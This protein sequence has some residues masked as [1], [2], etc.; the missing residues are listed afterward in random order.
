MQEIE[1]FK[2]EAL[3]RNLCGE[4]HRLWD[5]ME[6]REDFLQFSLNPKSI[7]YVALSTWEGWGL[8]TEY[9]KKEFSKHINRANKFTNKAFLYC[10][11]EGQHIIDCTENNI[12][13][14]TGV[15]IIQKTKCPIIHVN[16][17][18]D[19]DVECKGMNIVKIYIYDTSKV[20]IKIDNSCKV[21]VMSLS[22]ES[23]IE[24]NV[25]ELMKIR[26][27]D[28]RHYAYGEGNY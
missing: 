26:H 1:R 2:K 6:T 20:N 22:E 13:D 4:F 7:S 16:N 5:K 14:T 15:F 28:V 10:R 11:A 18:S 24:C 9:I 3:N 17:N 8:S 12:M 21:F 19:I 27:G 23:F 25:P